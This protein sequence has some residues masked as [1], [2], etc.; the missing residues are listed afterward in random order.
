MWMV[1]K[2]RLDG[3]ESLFNGNEIEEVGGQQPIASKELNVN[4]KMNLTSIGAATI[5]TILLD[6]KRTRR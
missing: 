6:D 2:S 5:K 1:G 3:I 4:S